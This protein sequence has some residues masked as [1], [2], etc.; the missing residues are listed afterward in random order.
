MTDELSPPRTTVQ[1]EI[2]AS[3]IGRAAG[4]AFGKLAS[5]GKP[6][7]LRR[8]RNALL[9]LLIAG[10]AVGCVHMD[11]LAAVANRD[12][13]R[14]TILGIPDARFLPTDSAA[15]AALGSRLN[16]RESRYYA[17]LGRPTPPENL[18]AISGGGDNGAFGA[19]LLV[20]WSE[21]GTRPQFKIVTGISTGALIAPFAFL[22]S[23]YD[24]QLAEIYTG[25][26]QKDIF[27]R[28]SLL[29][30]FVSDG[31]AD[32]TPLQSLIA[33][34]VDAELV[35]RIADEYQHG[36]SLIVV[37][38]DLDAG[39]P[40]I[41]NIGAI[42]QIERPE[43]VDLIRKILLASASLPAIFPPV[44]FDVDVDGVKHQELHVDGGASMQ[45]FLYPATLR[46]GKMVAE[47]SRRRTAYVIRN[48][49][50]SETWR[51]VD[52]STFSI[53]E[54]ALATITTNSGLGDLYRI[55]LLARRDG[56]GLRFASIGPDFTEPHAAEFDHAYMVNLFEYA[57]AKALSGY[58]W[59][60]APPGF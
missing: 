53:A 26:E 5:F 29:A 42:A 9:L 52:R 38:T 13:G 10:S 18:L 54:R 51:E 34:Y 59:Q 27:E 39:V 45:T 32:T 43:A 2:L 14:A 33:K 41:W 55:Y 4:K 57:R 3:S 58:P 16:E 15:I 49:R 6:V 19:G 56:I 28:R 35:K 7:G 40:V 20:G 22:G 46:L 23:D 17:S 21:S 1:T 11:R 36:R 12:T 44:M 60:V 37:T 48:G 31:L 8:A 30:G 25:I 50:L 24:S 47:K